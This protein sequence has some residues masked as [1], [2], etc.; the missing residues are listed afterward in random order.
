MR[1]C[2]CACERVCVR[3]RAR[4]KVLTGFR[5]R[6]ADEIIVF[7]CNHVDEDDVRNMVGQNQKD[8]S[9]SSLKTY[10]RR[11]NCFLHVSFNLEQATLSIEDDT[12]PDVAI[13]GLVDL[14]FKQFKLELE[15]RPR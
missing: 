14:K 8:K 11:D 2:V 5:R 10:M 1:A 12:D 9:K 15:C 7:S 13:V 6:L 4:V 3:A